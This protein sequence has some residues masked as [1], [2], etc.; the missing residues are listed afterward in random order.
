MKKYSKLFFL[1]FLVAF[2]LLP[3]VSLADPLPLNL[4]YPEFG[5]YDLDRDQDLNQIIAWFYYFIV[6][7]A[8]IAA[9]FALI[10]GGFEW[11]TSAGNPSRVSSAKERMFS[12]MLG[13]VI[14]LASYLIL[15]VINPE[16]TTLQL[17]G[18]PSNPSS[19]PVP[20]CKAAGGTCTDSDSCFGPGFMCNP[21]DPL[22]C[23][24]CCCVPAYGP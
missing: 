20:P 23:S 10:V 21:D 14:I 8:G 6:A 18:L 12:A 11:L 9:F 13:L 15:Q 2:L 17:P 22:G 5:G 16:L 19:T 24:D 3:E 1:I 4:D 7:I